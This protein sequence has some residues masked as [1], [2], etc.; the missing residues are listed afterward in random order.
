MHIGATTV[1]SHLQ[2]DGFLPFLYKV[3]GEGQQERGVTKR[4]AVTAKTTGIKFQTEKKK[5]YKTA[6]AGH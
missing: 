2:P 5:E 6:R 1:A 4:Q 3:Y